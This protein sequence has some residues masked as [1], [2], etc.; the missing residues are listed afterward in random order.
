[1]KA[2]LLALGLAVAASGAAAAQSIGG[3]YDVTGTGLNGAPYGGTA[4][5]TPTS[6]TTCTI[7]WKT[8]P[9]TFQGICMRNGDS[10]AA[11]YVGEG[12]TGLVIY[13][14]EANGTLSGMWTVANANGAGTEI[15][16]PR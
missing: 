16:T 6:Q 5:I 4:V 1:M 9:Q 11:A 14:L 15:L 12:A 7:T 3:N 10:F 13:R 2:I 8:G